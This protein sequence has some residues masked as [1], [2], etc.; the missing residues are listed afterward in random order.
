MVVFTKNK[1]PNFFV[2]YGQKQNSLPTKNSYFLHLIKDLNLD[3]QGF[4]LFAIHS[5]V[6]SAE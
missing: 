6:F 2:D 3:L 1:E 5:I 4:D